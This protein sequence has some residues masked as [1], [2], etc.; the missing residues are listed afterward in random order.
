MDGKSRAPL[1]PNALEVS[2]LKV[3]KPCTQTQC[4]FSLS[5][6]QDKLSLQQKDNNKWNFLSYKIL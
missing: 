5:G 2:T 4:T 6:T 3:V 1:G